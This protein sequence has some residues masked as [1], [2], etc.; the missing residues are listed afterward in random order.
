MP[1]GVKSESITTKSKDEEPTLS[2]KAPK[3]LS[4]PFSPPD[5][6]K[7]PVQLE[8]SP[9][10]KIKGTEETMSSSNMPYLS[11]SP[12][13]Y[14]SH[15]FSSSSAAAVHNDHP[16]DIGHRSSTAE[17]KNNYGTPST[18]SK[19]PDPSFP[20]QY[21]ER[22]KAYID[23]GIPGPSKSFSRLNNS[24]DAEMIDH[25]NIE[26]RSDISKG[27]EYAALREAVRPVTNKELNDSLEMLKYDIHLEVQDLIREQV[28]QFAIARVRDTCCSC[29]R[30]I[31]YLNLMVLRISRMKL[32]R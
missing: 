25:A 21:K 22:V 9:P 32:L 14:Q 15:Q 2:P 16:D 5:S 1:R 23:A 26:V 10:I 11:K 13:P 12:E 3:L 7:L 30:V 31:A 18:R 28:R 27:D 19:Q 4:S 8:K 20:D 24:F 29:T 6:Q 17:E